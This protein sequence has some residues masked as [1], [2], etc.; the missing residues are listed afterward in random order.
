M[1]NFFDTLFNKLQGKKEITEKVEFLSSIERKYDDFNEGYEVLIQP[2]TFISWDISYAD[3]YQK[4]LG[5]IIKD[6]LG[7][8]IFYFI[9]PVRVGHLK[10]DNLKIKWNFSDDTQV[11]KSYFVSLASS[12]FKAVEEYLTYYQENVQF[13]KSYLPNRA[14]KHLITNCDGIFSILENVD[15]NTYEYNLNFENKKNY[16]NVEFLKEYKLNNYCKKAK[17]SKYKLLRNFKI[18]ANV[19]KHVSYKTNEINNLCQNK[20]MIFVDELNDV[21]GFIGQDTILIMPKEL[22]MHLQLDILRPA[23]GGGFSSVSLHI[24]DKGQYTS[25]PL[26][27]SNFGI[28][29]ECYIKDLS[30][31]VGCPY[32]LDDRGYDC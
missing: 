5:K 32:R 30:N 21:I 4:K 26:I 24:D 20:T 14:L 22:I 17:I 10:I 25:I 31:F 23:K 15:G 7:N 2:S 29:D 16:P 3:L 8:L 12:N 9:Y 6:E 18:K 11:I 28:Y 1:L 27:F 13:A 19:S